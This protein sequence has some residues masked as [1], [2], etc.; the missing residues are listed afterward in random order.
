MTL[1]HGW[2]WPAEYRDRIELA[3][4]LDLIVAIYLITSTRF[5][6]SHPTRTWLIL[7]ILGLGTLLFGVS[8]DTYWPLVGRALL[9][10]NVAEASQILHDHP[11]GNTVVPGG[12][13]M[14]LCAAIGALRSIL[15]RVIVGK[16]EVG[17]M[18]R[19]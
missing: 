5:A 4:G 12:L 3:L 10:G 19:G 8:L 6:A 9:V 1:G 11:Y 13:G 18:G 16:A 14:M 2:L 15:S 7:A 17:E